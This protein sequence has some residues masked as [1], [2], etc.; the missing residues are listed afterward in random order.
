M[1]KNKGFTLLIAI[2]VTS[3]M[4]IV[5][6]VVANVALKQ[7]VLADAGVES[8]YAFYNADSGADCAVYWDLKNGNGT[9]P[10]ATSTGGTISCGSTGSISSGSQTVSTVP[11]QSSVIG[12]GGVSNPT[13]IF[14][15]NYAK[16]CAIVRVTKQNDGYTTV[17]SRGY[18]NCDTSSIK[19]YERGITLTYQGNENTII[20]TSGNS[21]TTL[22]TY[23]AA[24]SAGSD[25][26]VLA[27]VTEGGSGTGTLT[28]CSMTY[29]GNDTEDPYRAFDNHMTSLDFTKWC[30]VNSNAFPQMLMYDFSGSTAYVVT[31]YTITTANDAPA[32]DPK[33]WT[34]QGCDGTCIINNPTGWVTLDTQTNQFSGAAR[35]QTNTYNISNSVAYQQYRLRI[36]ANNGDTSYIQLSELQMF[37]AS[38]AA[39][40][41]NKPTGT[42][43]NDVMVASIAVRPQTTIV[44]PPSG[45]TLIR[46][47][48]NATANSNS[49]ITYRKVAGASEASSYTWTF[50]SFSGAAGGIVAISG[51]NTT[52]PV[53]VE[54]AQNTTTL[55][56]DAPSVN[57]TVGNTVVITTH[58]TTNSSTWTPPSGMIEA[59]EAS[60]LTPTQGGGI[61]LEMNYKFQATAGATGIQSAT[62]GAGAVADSGN[63]SVVVIKQ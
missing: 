60:S 37:Q 39:I 17:D 41:I 63:A 53:D 3:M 16:G 27:D 35:Y 29:S 58:E 40:T 32:R 21:G 23:K 1:K 5:S 36:T 31:R 9:S 18:N 30:V 55:N 45:W 59:L 49:L 22:L 26:S 38:G 19:R 14:Q 57:T 34:F 61:S 15:L 52:S 6:F 2:V 20:G 44:T 12:G 4:L 8:Q 7:L 62:Q 47:I 33:D 11:T 28:S 43:Q 42:V 48:D 25:S 54:N 50:D 10:F 13:S 56:V 51:A 24:A 46:R